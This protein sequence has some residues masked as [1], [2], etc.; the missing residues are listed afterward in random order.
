MSLSRGYSTLHIINSCTVPLRVAAY[1]KN[2]SENVVEKSDEI[3]TYVG[4]VKEN[5]NHEYTLDST[6][7]KHL[8]MSVTLRGRVIT[9]NPHEPN[10]HNTGINSS[11]TD[12]FK[13]KHCDK[14]YNRCHL[15]Q[16]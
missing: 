6:I 7:K 10:I 13:D 12:I 16:S 2:H 8:E 1:G 15:H 14:R 5:D 11:L 4:I 3:Q 9:T